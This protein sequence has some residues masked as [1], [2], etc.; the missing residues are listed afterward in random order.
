MHGTQWSF[1]G[2]RNVLNV[3][4]YCRQSEQVPGAILAR[5]NEV[6]FYV[7]SFNKW[8]LPIIPGRL[9]PST[10]S[11]K[12]LNFRVRYGYGCF[13]LAIA[14]TFLNNHNSLISVFDQVFDILVQ[15]GSKYYYSYTYCLSTL[16]SSRCLT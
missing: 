10:F 2:K 4:E 13:P 15:L 9:Q 8:R 16:W 3:P 12:S 1:V 6:T 5:K 11:V 7:T 14:A